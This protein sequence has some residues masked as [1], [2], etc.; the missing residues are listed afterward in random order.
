MDAASASGWMFPEEAESE[1]TQ[2][3]CVSVGFLFRE[4]KDTVCLMQTYSPDTQG[5][6]DVI[7]IP[8]PMIVAKQV[9][10]AQ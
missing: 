1:A 6:A 2:K 8:K 10:H 9:I 3:A 7:A 4:T 5:V